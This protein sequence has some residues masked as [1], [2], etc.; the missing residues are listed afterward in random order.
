MPEIKDGPP[1]HPLDKLDRIGTTVD[2]HDEQW[3]EQIDV[4]RDLRSRVLELERRYERDRR[5]WAMWGAR[6]LRWVVYISGGLGTYVY[7][8]WDR[9]EALF[10]TPDRKS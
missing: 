3:A 10:S 7:H 8:N 4:N 1:E 6:S 2:L 9:I 5:F